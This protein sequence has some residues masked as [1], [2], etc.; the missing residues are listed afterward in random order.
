MTSLINAMVARLASSLALAEGKK[1]VIC[2]R[3]MA[4]DMPTGHVH[5]WWMDCCSLQVEEAEVKRV[6]FTFSDPKD[7]DLVRKGGHW[8]FHRALVVLA[9]YDGVAAIDK[10]TMNIMVDQEQQTIIGKRQ[11]RIVVHH[12][13]GGHGYIHLSF[14]YHGQ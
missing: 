14:Y 7:R 12:A 6:L 1:S 11:G 3:R 10:G 5:I 9:Y 4:K 8:G 13:I 2:V